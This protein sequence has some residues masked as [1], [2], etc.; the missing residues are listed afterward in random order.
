MPQYIS[1]YPH[2]EI[3]GRAIWTTVMG[4]GEAILPVLDAYGL[5]DLEPETWY[6][7][8][9]W[10]DV[11]KAL[12]KSNGKPFDYELV[13]TGIRA[14]QGIVFEA[15]VHTIPDAIQA[16]AFIYATN[17]RHKP[18]HEGIFIERVDERRLRVTM[19][20]PYPN[21]FEYGLLHGT[22]HRFQPNDASLTIRYDLHP[23]SDEDACI[24]HIVW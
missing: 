19:R 16:L 4:M 12:D 20:T 14:A 13:T 2:T 15:N 18:P 23:C 17:H 22:A 1:F 21:S 7:Q 5:D 9:V 10:L 6:P 8:Q 11:L 24:Y 3:R